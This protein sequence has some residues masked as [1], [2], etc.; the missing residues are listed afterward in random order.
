MQ[1]EDSN[2]HTDLFLPLIHRVEQ[3]VGQP[4]D[5]GPAGASFRVLA[6]HARAVTFLLG[7]DCFPSNEGRGY[8][9]R[10]I[11]R[12][13]VRHAWLLGRREPTLTP[14]T[15]VVVHEMGEVYPALRAKAGQIR[16]WTMMEEERFLETIE[17][18]L[19]RLDSLLGSGAAVIPG[20]EVFKLYD[21]FGFPSISRCSSRKSGGVGGRRRV[22]DGVEQTAPA[23]SRRPGDPAGRR[24][25]CACGSTGRV[26]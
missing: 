26:A 5:R 11:L 1:G 2:F 20:E 16:Q 23:L 7:D 14:L 15:D 6:D 18:G 8:V 17:G 25:G 19:T 9:L 4:Y 10:R 22:R 24:P 21:T 3:L 13:A 12:R